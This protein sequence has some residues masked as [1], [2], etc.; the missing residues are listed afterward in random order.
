MNRAYFHQNTIKPG[1]YSKLRLYGQIKPESPVRSL[2]HNF[3]RTKTAVLSLT[4]IFLAFTQISFPQSLRVVSGTLVDA[5]KMPIPG[6]SI[7][8]KGTNTAVISDIDGRYSIKAPLGATLVYSFIGFSNKEVIVTFGNSQPATE[9]A[10]VSLPHQKSSGLKSSFTPISGLN[11][12]TDETEGDTT[13]IARFTSN[14]PSFKIHN[15]NNQWDT[16]LDENSRIASLDFKKDQVNVNIARDRYLQ[17]PHITF[18]TSS[19]ADHIT[20]MPKRQ[21]QFAQGRP[22]N[23]VSQWRGPETGEFL[24]WGP[25]IRNLEYDGIANNY[26]KNGNLVLKG[27]G[28]GKSANSYNPCDIFKTG[29]TL[30]NNL[31]ISAKNDKKEYALVYNNKQT[32]G[33]LPNA[34]KS[35]NFIEYKLVRKINKLELKTQ[36]VYDGYKSKLMSASP[37]LTLLMASIETTP[38]TFDNT[39]GFSRKKAVS[40][41]EAYLLSDNSQRTYSPGMSNNPYWLINNM[42]DD[43]RNTV[44]SGYLETKY[45]FSRRF[46]AFADGSIESQ[47]FVNSFGYE[48]VPGGVKTVMNTD[49]T[50]KLQ[51]GKAE[52]GVKYQL[53]GQNTNFDASLVYNYT[54]SSRS[55]DRNDQVAGDASSLHLKNNSFME[56][57][58]AAFTSNMTF[59]RWLLAKVSQN[60]TH[61]TFY[62]KFKEQFSPSAALAVNFHEMRGFRYNFNTITFLKIRS[63]WGYTFSGISLTYPYGAY[64]FQGISS[65]GYADANFTN[66][67][68]PNADL[69]PERIRKFGIGLDAGIFYNKL[70]LTFD[71]YSNK[72]S[73]GIFPY[74]QAN[75]PILGNQ[76]DYTS[77]GT[78]LDLQY[79]YQLG[80]KSNASI[81]LL[82]SKNTTKVTRLANNPDNLPLGGFADVYTALVKGQPK[83][84]IVGTAYKRNDHGQLIIDNDGYPVVDEKLHVLGNPNPDFTLGTELIFNIHG[85]SFTTLLEAGIGG[86][87]WNGSENALSY[88]GLSEKTVDGRKVLE[89]VYPGVKADG[90]PNTTPVDFAN[91]SKPIDQ[92]RWYRYGLTGVAENAIQDA[93]YFRI[94]QVT[95]SFDKF[96]GKIHKEISLFVENPLLLTKYT[97]VDPEATLWGKSTT[98][99][100]DLFNFPSISRIGINFKIA[101]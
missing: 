66:E 98:H 85:F 56:I 96:R 42:I 58:N 48:D 86:K 65:S 95:I 73:H 81:H 22:V 16:R 90:T 64:N 94:K 34:S 57:H 1:L 89:Y 67:L 62:R 27:L 44:L 4:L 2:K 40:N 11:E 47:K 39:N 36:L 6:V 74:M 101:L 14:T 9:D 79:S 87:R 25:A 55:L 46:S 91:P 8:I 84:V 3:V 100:L 60:F 97:G 76:A 33:V 59:R 61:N 99:G 93:S 92:N 21:D 45:Q 15:P 78:E 69:Q 80:Y 5:D 17:I 54:N 12:F 13:G 82:F 38:P 24:S 75:A 71:V 63:T 51:T 72:I 10:T 49:R 30:Q 28:D 50:D 88:Y 7:T 31:K 18:F 41:K 23:G 77:H 52:A 43:E 53:L 37:G 26:D 83:G 68:L 20:R 29:F 70:T 35:G 19:S 32:F